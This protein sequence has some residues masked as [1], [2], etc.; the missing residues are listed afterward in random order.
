M[1]TARVIDTQHLSTLCHE[2]E[3]EILQFSQDLTGDGPSMGR[4][5][6]EAVKVPFA[7][8]RVDPA[9]RFLA[10]LG[11]GKNVIAMEAQGAA[12]TAGMLYAARLIHDLCMYDDF[13]LWVAIDVQKDLLGPAWLQ[14]LKDE[15]ILPDC[16][17]LGE[18]TNLCIRMREDAIAG[19]LTESHPLVEAAIATYEALFELPPILRRSPS[20]GGPIGIPVIGFGPGEEQQGAM[21]R[22][23]LQAAQFYAAF[24]TM[25]VEMMKQR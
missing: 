17:L 22:H 7:E 9:G 12:E 20:L 8:V 21:T 13:T 16:L 24:P 19:F 5:Q 2:H 14:T 4:I 25:F 23:L 1:T 18:P 3:R 6:Q 11:S 15:G 10:R